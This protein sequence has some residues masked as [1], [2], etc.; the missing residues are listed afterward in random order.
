MLYSLWFHRASTALIQGEWQV[1]ELELLMPL[2]SC[3]MGT[4][5]VQGCPQAWP[6]LPALLRVMGNEKRVQH[7]SGACCGSVKRASSSCKLGLEI[8]TWKHSQSGISHSLLKSFFTSSSCACTLK[9]STVFS[10][11]GRELVAWS[12]GRAQEKMLKLVSSMWNVPFC[13]NSLELIRLWNK[14]SVNSGHFVP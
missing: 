12:M 9:W 2:P 4:E 14:F 3:A 8:E 13:E 5:G 6:A 7:D 1:Q 11:L 10:P